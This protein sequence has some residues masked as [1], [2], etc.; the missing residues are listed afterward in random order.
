MLASKICRAIASLIFL[1][2]GL[3]LSPSVHGANVPETPL[4]PAGLVFE[5]N[6][7][8]QG[9]L[10][11]SDYGAG[12]IRRIH[13]ATGA[14]TL[15]TDLAGASDAR[16][17]SA[18]NVWW[19][20]FANQ[21]YRLVPGTN[22]LTQW[23]FPGATSLW[24]TAIDQTGRVWV[25]DNQS[26]N[27]YRFDP[28]NQQI[29]KHTFPGN[30]GNSYLFWYAGFIWFANDPSGQVYRFDPSANEFKIWQI[31]ASRH[32]E[33]ATVDANGQIW[34]VERSTPP[35][36]GR[37]EPANNQVTRYT[38]PTDAN[39][40]NLQHS[41]GKV[42][43]TATR[44]I[45]VLDPGVVAGSVSTVAYTTTTVTPVCDIGVG[46]SGSIFHQVGVLAW[47]TNNYTLTVNSGGWRV[48]ELPVGGT[49]WDLAITDEAVWLAD[50][51]RQMLGR[52]DF[53]ARVFLPV[54]LRNP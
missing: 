5:V 24:G 30:T 21:L 15:Y 38:L 49:P 52:I 51:G 50:Q 4:N 54:I 26:P 10:W 28:S 39:P 53:Y 44:V 23:D 43:Y 36:L 35:A 9:Y 8:P 3:I 48:Y 37:L 13:P 42:W 14:Y 6:L 45:G 16:M 7:D 47:T 40:N 11:V 20:S 32:P 18:G 31:G 25:A 41:N 33:A 46:N 17:D 22:T 19:T 29:C 34:W 27:I 12:E 2:I 1:V